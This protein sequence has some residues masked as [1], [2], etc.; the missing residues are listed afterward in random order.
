[1]SISQ[2][3]QYKTAVQMHVFQHQRWNQWCLFFFGSI[4]SVFVLWAQFKAI[5]P[6]WVPASLGLIIS[7]AWVYSALGI[8]S[9]NLVWQEIIEDLEDGPDTDLKIHHEF[10][11]RR[12]V[13]SHW[14][15]FIEVL[16]FWQPRT[17]YSVSRHLIWFGLISALAFLA[18]MVI[19]LCNPHPIEMSSGT[20]TTVTTTT[21]TTTAP[22]PP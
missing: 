4:A 3:E 13:F 21:T 8:R 9:V 1:M 15:E 10:V 11:R 20:M 18:L 2:E 19:G 12:K 7:V 6:L 17:R 16:K 22:P 14:G 5:V